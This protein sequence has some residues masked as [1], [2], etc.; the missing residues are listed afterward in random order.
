MQ[1]LRVA[2][3]A[4][5]STV[6]TN[7]PEARVHLGPIVEDPD[8]APVAFH[9]HE[10]SF[11][12]LSKST[13]QYEFSN[14]T[15]YCAGR[16][17]LALQARE[18]AEAGTPFI[19]ATGETY[20]ATLAAPAAPAAPAPAAANSS[21]QTATQAQPTSGTGPVGEGSDEQMSLVLIAALCGACAGALSESLQSCRH[22][23]CL[24]NL[25][26]LESNHA[27]VSSYMC[28]SGGLA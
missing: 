9:I 21:A 17:Q 7:Q 3:Q 11:Q 2:P 26:R 28:E 20:T 8:G 15:I 10:A 16:L 12:P 22:P 4:L 25:P 14:T 24:N 18:A 23:E 1:F 13:V 5:V 19:D 6:L 27:P